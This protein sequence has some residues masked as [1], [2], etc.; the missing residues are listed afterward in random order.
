MKAQ[1]L[2]GKTIAFA[3]SGGL[4]SCT[5]TRWLTDMGVQVI[6]FTADLGQPDE[7][8]LDVV[9]KRMLLAGAVDFVLLPAR[10]PIAEAGLSVIQSQAC[11]EGRYWNTTG[12]ARCVLAK[13]MIEEMQKRGLTIFSH[14]AT[15]R[16]NDQV[17]FQLITNMLA[18]EF[19]VYAPWRDEEFLARFPGRSEMIDFCQAKGL[20]VTATKDKPYSTDANMLGLTHE[21]GHLEALTTPA[22]FV[23]PIMGCYPADAPDETGEFTVVFEKGRPISV[24]GKSVNLVEAIVEAN[25]I[26]GRY[27]I[28]IGT[29]LVENRF[30]GI[31][32]RGVYESPGVELLGTCYAFLLQLILDRRAREFYDQLSLL[33]AKQIYQGYWFDLATQMALLAIG[34]TAELATGTITVSVYKGNISF[35]SA[36]N[37]PHSLYSEENAS[38]EGIGSYNH[39]DS[40]GLLRVFGVSARVLATSGQI[41][42]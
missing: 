25:A 36:S 6:C 35:V 8:D 24:N 5:I 17:R 38:M 9:R 23:K 28:G 32:S 33:I 34:R 4:D 20:P 39:A 16:G 15:G 12:I 40:E 27:G 31:K 10:E 3:G 22:H 26:G 42:G 2:V 7:E 41:K 19:E 30:V 13:A 18:P 29:H 11:Y 14:G 21:S 37:T 1:D